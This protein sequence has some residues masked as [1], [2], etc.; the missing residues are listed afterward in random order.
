VDIKA[1]AGAAGQYRISDAVTGEWLE[2]T[3]DVASAGTYTF[4]FRV[5]NRDPGSTFH[6]E[7]DGANVSGTMSVPDTNSFDTFATV[8]ADIALAAGEQVVRFVFDAPGSSGYG[9]A[10]DWMRISAA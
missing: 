7:I 6:V 4:E 1:I 5:G 10:F 9:A 3:I 2:Y 8:S